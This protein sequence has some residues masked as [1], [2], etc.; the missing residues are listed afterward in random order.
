M[1]IR[2]Q[3]AIQVGL[4]YHPQHIDVLWFDSQSQAQF[5]QC[6]E[7]DLLTLSSTLNQKLNHREE[8]TINTSPLLCR[9]IFGK[10]VLFCRRI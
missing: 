9:S 8:Q 4:C 7:L 10:R 3:P 2:H 1:F 6:H 5:L